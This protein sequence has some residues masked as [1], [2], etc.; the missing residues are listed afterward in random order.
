MKSIILIR[1]GQSKHHVNGLTGGWTDD[2]LTEQGR[3]QAA[4][5]ASRLKKDIGKTPCYLY[6]SDLKR[7]LQ[8][9]EI[10]GGKLNLT[11]KLFPELREFNNGIAAGKTREEAKKIELSVDGQMADWRPYPDSETWI[12]FYER[13]A[14]CIEKLT[15]EQDCL[16]LLVTHGG[17][18][19]NIISWWLEMR[20]HLYMKTRKS[21]DISPAS[22]TVLRLNEW[23]ERTVER[24]ND[25]AHLYAIGLADGIKY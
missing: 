4:Y 1:H 12:T 25:T 23:D 7:A 2:D 18:I 6:S 22:V 13:V 10:I 9:A 11:P 20:P 8:T 17:T 5:L 21:F 14:S 3:Q 15:Q 24:L 16:L 19:L